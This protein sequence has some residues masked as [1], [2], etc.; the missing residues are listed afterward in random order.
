MWGVG[1]AEK[2]TAKKGTLELPLVWTGKREKK[3]DD[4]CPCVS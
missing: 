3:M 2:E 4:L 1:T